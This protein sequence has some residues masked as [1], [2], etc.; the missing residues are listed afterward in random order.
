MEIKDWKHAIDLTIELHKK[1]IKSKEDFGTVK[2]DN[3][4][5]DW[6]YSCPLCEY[7]KHFDEDS[8]C[9]SCLWK[10]FAGDICLSHI[11]RVVNNKAAIKR[12]QEWK[13]RLNEI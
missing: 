10:I 1:A 9:S 7:S 8:S 2:M 4:P 5:S 6:E 3:K 12:L 13:E 11:S